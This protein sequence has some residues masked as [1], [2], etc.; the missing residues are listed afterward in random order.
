M[1]DRLLRAFPGLLG[2]FFGFTLLKFGNPPILEKWVEAPGNIYEFFLGT[3]WPIAWAYMPLAVISFFGLV[4]AAQKG[5]TRSSAP[6]WLIILPVAWLAWQAVATS[7]SVSP[8]LSWATLKHFVACTV[9]FYLGF[10]SLRRVDRLGSFWVGPVCAFLIVL[11]IGWEQ[12]FGGLEATRKFFFQEI[13]PK[14]RTVPPEYLKKISSDRVFSTLFYPNALAGALLL[15]LPVVCTLIAQARHLFTFPARCLLMGLVGIGA[16]GCLYWSGSKGGWLIMLLI[17]LLALLQLR[18]AKGLRFG[19]L[20]AVMLVGLAGFLLKYASFFQQGATSISAR[21]D[22]WQAAFKTAAEHPWVGTGP[23]T[24][25]VPYEKIKRPES[26]I[27]RMVHNDYL[28]QA[29]DSGWLG[30]AAYVAFVVTGLVA[31]A[32]VAFCKV[33]SELSNPARANWL[34][35]S[36]WLGLFGWATQGIFEFGLYIPALA[37]PTFALFG[38]V[39]G[40]LPNPIDKPLGHP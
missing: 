24:F 34:T 33:S 21:A 2:A 38:L 35:F 15:F 11:A 3:P 14:L 16:L 28:E 1:T 5:Q 19:L 7:Q 29:S 30:F 8:E 36:V 31:T 39:L 26:E 37:W 4:I 40:R 32:P 17:A 20:A 10:F 25:L 22:Y 12:H 9:C 23:G 27:T 18:L 13:Y 6:H